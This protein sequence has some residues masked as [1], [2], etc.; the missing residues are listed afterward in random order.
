MSETDSG[1]YIWLGKYKADPSHVQ[2]QKTNIVNG[3]NPMSDRHNKIVF[4]LNIGICKN[5]NVRTCMQLNP[6]YYSFSKND[7]WNALYYWIFK[8]NQKN[9]S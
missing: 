1:K 5:R 7:E 9:L 8:G 4:A 6:C 3:S 2:V